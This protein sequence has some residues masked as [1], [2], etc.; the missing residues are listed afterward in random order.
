MKKLKKKFFK[1]DI[2]V[3]KYLGKDSF[4]AFHVNWKIAHYHFGNQGKELKV[5]LV[6]NL[7]DS[8]S[9]IIRVIIGRYQV[10]VEIHPHDRWDAE[11][12]WQIKECLVHDRSRAEFEEEQKMRK[13]GISMVAPY[14]YKD[15]V[16]YFRV[17]WEFSELQILLGDGSILNERSNSSLIRELYAIPGVERVDLEEK[18]TL[19]IER[20]RYFPWIVLLA[21]IRLA[22]LRDKYRSEGTTEDEELEESLDDGQ[23]LNGVVVTQH[24]P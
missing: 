19:R 4:L 20:D 22:L 5:P 11:L 18:D 15:Y 6:Q 13:H 10:I 21:Q 9:R 7:Y 24:I 1:H 16:R 2:R 8:N 3:K 14:E 23:D 12:L 17:P